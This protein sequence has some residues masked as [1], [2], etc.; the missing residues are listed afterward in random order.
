[1]KFRWTKKESCLFSLLLLACLSLSA[2]ADEQSPAISRLG[3]L[4]LRI[5]L[6]SVEV[7]EDFARV[8][9]EEVVIS[10]QLE[11]EL[12]QVQAQDSSKNRRWSSATRH[13][14]RQLA[15]AAESL[16]ESSQITLSVGR[17]QTVLINMDDRLVVLSNP[18][19][20]AQ[21]DMER[22]IIER[23]CSAQPCQ[24]WQ[25]TGALTAPAS[26]KR[27]SPVWTFGDGGSYSCSNGEGL[28]LGFTDIQQMA[29]KKA[30]CQQLFS[31]LYTLVSALQ[32]RLYHGENIDWGGLQILAV[33]GDDHHRVLLG[34]QAQVM[35]L[36]LP[37]CAAQP[38]LIA[39]IQPWL[40]AR[41][42]G[43]GNVLSV[44]NV[45]PLLMSPLLPLIDASQS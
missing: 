45:E 27:Q 12:A 38:R 36:V 4:A 1:M 5:N 31:E 32:A 26:L 17:E 44:E 7:R 29:E 35:W 37:I 14:A 9:I 19:A 16:S 23:F 22:R 28:S 8:A 43:A 25:V 41:A 10:L 21:T 6:Q 24:D 42:L 40:K 18:R 2:H 30:F 15:I 3:Q 13:Y 39:R 11:S 34:T 33:P 20:E